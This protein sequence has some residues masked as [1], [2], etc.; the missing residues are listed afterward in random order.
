MR[1]DCPDAEKRMWSILRSRKLSGFKFRRQYPIGGYIVDFYCLRKRLAIEL[2]GGQHAD[3]ENLKY[4]ERRTESLNALGVRVMRFWDHDVLRDTEAVA[5]TIW[6]ILTT[7]EEPSPRPSPGVPGEG[8]R[9]TDAQQH[10][11][12]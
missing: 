6:R 11:G 10:G 4:D 2:D 9:A 3:E 7:G 5:E 8:E 12:I 1:R